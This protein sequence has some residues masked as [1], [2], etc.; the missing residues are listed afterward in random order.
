M[1][2]SLFFVFTTIAEFTVVLLV[3]RTS[4][5]KVNILRPYSEGFTGTK[6]HLNVINLKLDDTKENKSSGGNSTITN[7][8]GLKSLDK[9][10]PELTSK[11]A[12]IQNLKTTTLIDIVA[13]T[14]FIIGFLI[15]NMIYYTRF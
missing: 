1:L 3:N 8:W 4:G 14:I 11:W 10:K 9:S 12:T 7:S 5:H 13:F 2:T 15:F 6:K